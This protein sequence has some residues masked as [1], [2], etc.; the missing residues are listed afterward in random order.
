MIQ[1]QA[2]ATDPETTEHKQESIEALL[3]DNDEE[4]DDF[5]PMTPGS[6]DSTSE[7]MEFPDESPDTSLCTSMLSMSLHDTFDDISKPEDEGSC[8]PDVHVTKIIK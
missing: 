1:P 4:D 6:N 5:R 8:L 2:V 3:S 7:L